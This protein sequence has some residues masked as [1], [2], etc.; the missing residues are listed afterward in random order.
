MAGTRRVVG[1]GQGVDCSMIEMYRPTMDRL[2]REDIAVA[3]AADASLAPSTTA[4]TA[5]GREHQRISRVGEETC[6]GHGG[7]RLDEAR[8]VSVGGR[9]D[10]YR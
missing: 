2:A 4:R 8:N 1:G 7:Y 9:D 5:G 10:R 3:A 6:D